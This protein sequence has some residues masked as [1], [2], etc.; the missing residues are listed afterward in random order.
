M[1]SETY[2]KLVKTGILELVRE[3]KSLFFIL[4]FPLLFLAMFS[5]M[6]SIIPKSNSSELSFLEFMFPG[7]LVFALLST[8]LFG[9][10]VPL[11]EM[12]KNGILRL[13]QITPLKKGTFIVSQI[14]VRL[15]LACVQVMVF[16]L[17]GLALNLFKIN[18]F[19]SVLAT[20]LLGMAMILTL[21]FLLGGIFKSVELTGG[22]LGALSAPLL[23][24]SGV[25]LPLR[26]F[27]KAFEIVSMFIPITYLGD[28]IRTVM[29]PSVESLH[30]VYINI[31]AMVLFTI[32]FY[33]ICK[34][35]FK[36]Q[37]A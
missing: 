27:P 18:Q 13:F 37:N 15:L 12:R 1:E 19:F 29:Y 28:L 34:V 22:L 33:F 32:I 7:I 26:L 23:M 20:S 2:K 25:L 10:A 35:T 4:I 17:I 36:W 21:G 5:V 9:T 16:L 31:S 30:P 11:V 8:G 3:P 24:L 14:T 6:G